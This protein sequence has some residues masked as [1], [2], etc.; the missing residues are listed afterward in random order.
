MNQNS[1]NPMMG[2]AYLA[3]LIVLAPFAILFVE[4][5]IPLATIVLIGYVVYHLKA[6][7]KRTNN[8]TNLF[9]NTFK[10]N[11]YHHREIYELPQGED[12]R[13]NL[14]SPSQSYEEELKKLVQAVN[15]LTSD[16]EEREKMLIQKTIDDYGEKVVEKKKEEV[17]NDIYGTQPSNYNQS[18]E[19]ERK[20]YADKKKKKTQELEIRELKHEVNEQLFEQKKETFEVRLEGREDRGKIRMEMKDGFIKIEGLLMQ[21]ENKVITLKGYCDEKFA[22]MEVAFQKEISNVHEK[23]ADLRINVEKGFANVKDEFSNVKLSFGKEILRVDKAQMRIV[24]KLGEYE[25]R[26]KEFSLQAKQL[27]MESERFQIRGQRVL[28]K[29]EFLYQ[30]HSLDMKLAG[31]NI[32]V[33][34]EKI[35]LHKSDFALKAGQA[36]LQLDKISQDQYLELKNIGYAEM[37]V[38]MLRQDFTQREEIKQKEMQNLIEKKRRTEERIREY[39]SRGLE[40][41]Q[42]RHRNNMLDE[43]YQH[44][45]HTKSIMQREHNVFKRLSKG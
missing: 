30:K 9:E 21:L 40:T 16:K 42:L 43:K 45:S 31:K 10:P 23:I 38:K 12:E 15:H 7:D 39:H 27:K 11:N 13:K 33:G 34:L 36:K 29:A 19:F 25:N 18:E 44:A 1:P 4:S 22:R 2:C 41:A 32:E 35:S 8:L 26:V 37:G 24:N 6:W 3:L 14:P 5:V 20:Q 17:L 28:E